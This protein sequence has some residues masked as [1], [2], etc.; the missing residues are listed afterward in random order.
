MCDMLGNHY[1]RINKFSLAQEEFEKVIKK[2]PLNN[3]V[4]KKLIICYTQTDYVE[5]ALDMLIEVLKDDIYKIIKTDQ[6]E[7]N[8]PCAEL[9]S[10]T[11]EKLKNEYTEKNII[12]LSIL[13][14]FCD[15]KKSYKNFMLLKQDKADAKISSI[16][17]IIENKASSEIQLIN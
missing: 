12:I 13:L 15:V 10:N 17:N 3:T 6:A 8:C 11:Y 2:N 5:K 4:K 16:I 7:E 14:L 9:I 1:F